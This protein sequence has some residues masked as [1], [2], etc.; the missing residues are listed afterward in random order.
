MKNQHNFDR[1]DREAD[2]C[3]KELALLIY[4]LYMIC[5]NADADTYDDDNTRRQMNSLP[6]SMASDREGTVMYYLAQ[7]LQAFDIVDWNMSGDGELFFRPQPVEIEFGSFQA[8]RWFHSHK[9]HGPRF[10]YDMSENGGTRDEYYIQIDNGGQFHCPMIDQ[11]S[12]SLS[13]LEHQ[14]WMYATKS[15]TKKLSGELG[16]PSDT[17]I[18]PL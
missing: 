13:E 16:L 14:L 15:E 8:C 12:D 10:C 17:D 1:I 5:N 2:I 6:N 7:A 11:C 3:E 9:L 4:D 18:T